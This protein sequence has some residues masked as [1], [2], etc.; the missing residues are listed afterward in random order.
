MYGP[1]LSCVATEKV[2]SINHLVPM[3]ITPEL[4]IGVPVYVDD[5]L[6]IG[7]VKTVERVIRNTREM[8]VKKKFRFSRKKSKYMMINTGRVK[9]NV[10]NELVKG[11]EI[12]RTNEYKYV[13]WWFNEKNNADRQT[14]ELESKLDYM[15][16]EVQSAGSWTKWGHVMHRYNL[17]CIRE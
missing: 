4:G 14:E 10:V 3:Y 6:G 11:G 5:I 12:E 16:K 17:C 8:K 1:K 13:G 15:V 7:S 9:M 2:N